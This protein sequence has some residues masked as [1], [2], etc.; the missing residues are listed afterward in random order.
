MAR[1]RA[2]SH[3][4]SKRNTTLN[5]GSFQLLSSPGLGVYAQV[6]Q[7]GEGEEKVFPLNARW[8]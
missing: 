5:L 7:G 8:V 4:Q 2:R 1:S 3:Q 6:I